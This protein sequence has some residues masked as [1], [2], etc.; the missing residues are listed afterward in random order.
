MQSDDA[1][2]SVLIPAKQAHMLEYV[3]LWC[4]LLILY[5]QKHLE[6]KFNTRLEAFRT[7]TIKHIVVRLKRFLYSVHVI[8][9]HM[10]NN[11]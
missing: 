7:Q 2:L 11:S 10:Q 9:K 4:D 5:Y 1:R 8:G 6:M 3:F